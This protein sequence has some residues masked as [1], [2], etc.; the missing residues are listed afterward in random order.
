ML[1]YL[2]RPSA[3]TPSKMFKHPKIQNAI[4][5]PRKRSDATKS[6]APDAAIMTVSNMIKESDME[7]IVNPTVQH[8]YV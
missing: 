2:F 8:I 1:A 3:I 7:T 6:A 5:D 4:I